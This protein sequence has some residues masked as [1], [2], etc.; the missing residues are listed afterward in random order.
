MKYIII[1]LSLLLTACG[2]TQLEN[3]QTV[4]AVLIVKQDFNTV[5]ETV[6]KLN[7]TQTQQINIDTIMSAKQ[8]VDLVLDSSNLLDKVETASLLEMNYAA[9]KTA[10]IE[11]RESINLDQLN[12]LDVYHLGQ[13]DNS[14]VHLSKQISK[15][16]E[17]GEFEDKK[18]LVDEVLQMLIL[19]LQIVE[20]TK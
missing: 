8:A 3:A 6:S 2:T 18:A 11:L 15:I 5:Y 19:S 14:V 9:A 17:N 4:R 10:Y 16:A 13:F 7:L 20:L 12:P 1:A